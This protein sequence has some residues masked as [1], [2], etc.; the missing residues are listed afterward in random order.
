MSCLNPQLKMKVLCNL[1]LFLYVDT[2]EVIEYTEPELHEWGEKTRKTKQLICYLY[3]CKE[4][5]V[6]NEN[7]TSAQKNK[8]QLHRQYLLMILSKI[9]RN[10][11]TTL[12]K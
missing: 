2:D 11:L 10:C 7:H 4:M 12:K 1:D 9:S 8:K 5:K 6:S 3:W